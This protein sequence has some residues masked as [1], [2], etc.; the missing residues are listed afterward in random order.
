[1]VTQGPSQPSQALGTCLH[2]ICESEFMAYTNL[3]PL[4]KPAKGTT[5]GV[6]IAAFGKVNDVQQSKNDYKTHQKQGNAEGMQAASDKFYSLLR[7]DAYH[8]G[9][10]VISEVTILMKETKKATGTPPP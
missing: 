7:D 3:I 4:R 1:M 2:D 10:E 5:F 6:L 9:K 8:Y